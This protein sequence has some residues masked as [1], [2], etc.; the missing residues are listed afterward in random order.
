MKPVLSFVF[1]LYAASALA[2]VPAPGQGDWVNLGNGYYRGSNWV[3]RVTSNC[4]GGYSYAKAYPV[5]QVPV[6]GQPGFYEQALAS[7]TKRETESEERA[8]LTQMFPANAL[9][10]AGYQ[11]T[12]FNVLQQGYAANYVTGGQT[13]Q[14]SAAYAVQSVDVNGLVHEAQRLADRVL[15]ASEAATMGAQQL[16]QTAVDG[17]S[18]AA[19][20]TA[21]ASV[22]EAAIRAANPPTTQTQVYETKPVQP[23]YDRPPPPPAAPHTGDSGQINSALYGRIALAS[24]VK[25]H[26]GQSPKASLDLSLAALKSMG[27]EERAELAGRIANRISTDDAEKRMPKGQPPLLPKMRDG[28]LAIISQ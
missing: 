26:S 7:L 1:V 27:P 10:T 16:V 13:L 15:G 23:Q 12:G 11:T 2:Q 3:W 20:I 24:C 8:F 14:S 5:T 22:A 6:V 19:E 21:S 25:C 17:N 28:L 18:K 9:Q 4:C